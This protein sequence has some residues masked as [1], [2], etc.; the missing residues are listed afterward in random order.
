MVSIYVDVLLASNF[1]IHFLL[2]SLLQRLS[3]RK[4]GGNW[5][6]AGAAAV[7]ALFSLSIFLPP[8]PFEEA[9][10]LGLQLLSCT[11]M[12]RLAFRWQSWRR[13]LI[14]C[15]LLLAVS[16]GMFAAL[17]LL[18]RFYAGTG[19]FVFGNAIYFQIEQPAFVLCLCAAYALVWGIDR[20]LRG[21]APAC[22][23]CPATLT[24]AAKSLELTALIDTGNSLTE[25]F[26]GA[27]VAVC[28]LAVACQLFDAPMLEAVLHALFEE[29]TEYSADE[30]L[31]RVPFS[32]A[33][34]GGLLPAVRVDQLL[35]RS[36]EGS[37][38]IEDLFLAVCPQQRLGE[39]WELLVGD[40]AFARAQAVEERIGVLR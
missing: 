21:S 37:Y 22:K 29:E 27:P 13:F 10:Q 32:S 31:R 7:G 6:K 34:K 15:A 38:C 36:Q 25:P 16:C 3:G 14:E 5:R 26:S 9:F 39:E 40:N 18:R 23:F 4:P 8:L 30:P 35:I 19:L 12:V 24:V 1:L 20:L 28:G 2:L 17:S 33:G 11:L